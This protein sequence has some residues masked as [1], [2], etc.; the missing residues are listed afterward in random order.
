MSARLL[1]GAGLVTIGAVW[2][3]NN[4]G[5]LRTDI[6]IAPVVLILVGTAAVLTATRPAASP[7]TASESAELA[8]DGAPRAR[9]VLNHGAG[10]LR[11][12][13]GARDGL[14]YAG[15]FA[16]GV[17]QEIRRNGDRLEV[18]LQ[19]SPG[20][21]WLWRRTPITWDLGLAPDV[22]IDLEI[23][24]G[25]SRLELDLTGVAV[26]SLVLK[27]GA[28]DVRLVLPDHGRTSTEISAGAADVRITVP[29]GVA[30]SVRNRSA[31][32]GFSVDET[33][34][35]RANGGYRS[36][37]Y[38]TA[39]DRADIDIDGGVASFSIR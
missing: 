15:R 10:T 14:L 35:P 32:A 27:T 33:R 6:P 20:D 29:P 37:D 36:M 1:V 11:V 19:P 3:V 4:L 9:L 23:H 28:S 2:L 26:A 22:P 5:L 13:A 7:T 8:L 18:R 34:F 16:G 12:A 39:E 30:A 21:S 17:Q 31:L 38:D 25:A 24:T